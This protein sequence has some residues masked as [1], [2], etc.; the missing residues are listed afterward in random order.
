DANTAL[1]RPAYGI[2]SDAP[3]FTFTG[4]ATPQE[5]RFS[6]AWAS[7]AT[8]LTS[9]TVKRGLKLSEAGLY[10]I[11][12]TISAQV[13]GGNPDSHLNA[14]VAVNGAIV[15]RG[16]FTARHGYT[17]S[18]HVKRLLPLRAD[19]EITAR[20]LVDTGRTVRF[21]ISAGTLQGCRMSVR[22]I[23]AHPVFRWP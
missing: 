18:A 21:G 2:L 16:A 6:N 19:D 1:S 5:M 10:D 11:D 23:G 9:G 17:Q 15:A 13:D 14:L 3:S 8:V 4:E 22:R 20:V 12:L 7:K